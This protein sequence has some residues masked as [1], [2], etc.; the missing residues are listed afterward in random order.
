MAL[1]KACVFAVGVLSG[2]SVSRPHLRITEVST[3]STRLSGYE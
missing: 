3:S 1:S 2:S